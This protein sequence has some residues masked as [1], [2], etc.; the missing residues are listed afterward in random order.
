MAISPDTTNY[1]ISSG[2][3]P[4][5]GSVGQYQSA[6]MPFITGSSI[7]NNGMEHVID[8]PTVTRSITVINR[9]SGSGEAPDIRV[10]FAAT[11]SGHVIKNDHYI[12][13]TSNKDSMTM[14]V[15][16]S[17]LYISRNDGLA[18]AGAYT[19]FAECTGIPAGQMFPL[20]GSGITD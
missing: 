3:K 6:G 19:V 5:L 10:H 7:L 13:L 17:R 2:P 1:Q 14:N 16:C 4:G 20:T 12:L 15:K 18:T 8:F 9:P 11:G